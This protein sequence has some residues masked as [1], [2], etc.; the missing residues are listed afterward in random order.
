[1]S[2]AGIATAGWTGRLLAGLLGGAALSL[3]AM[4][5]IGRL[6]GCVAAPQTLGAQALMWLVAPIWCAAVGVSV[7]F[8]STARAWLGLAGPALLLW[9]GWF[10]LRAMT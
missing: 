7:L 3:G 8:G 1:M 4:A 10:G 9:L 5:V 2:T 6:S